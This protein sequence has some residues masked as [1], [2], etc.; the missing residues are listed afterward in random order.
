MQDAGNGVLVPSRAASVV[1]RPIVMGLLGFLLGVL[2]TL[3]VRTAV[4]PD[5]RDPASPD[6]RAAFAAFSEGERTPDLRSLVRG[7]TRDA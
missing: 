4:L 1:R 5:K 7:C 3:L 2:V 6:C